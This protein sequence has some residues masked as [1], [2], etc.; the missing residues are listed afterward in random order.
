VF[1]LTP[2]LTVLQLILNSNNPTQP[3]T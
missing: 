3:Q 2:V 1:G